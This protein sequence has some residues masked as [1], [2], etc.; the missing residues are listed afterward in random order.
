M[1]PG[2][3]TS[4]GSGDCDGSTDTTVVG[5]VCAVMDG[6]GLSNLSSVSVTYPDGQLPGESVRVSAQYEYN[7]ITPVNALINFFSAGSVGD[8]ITVSSTTDMRLE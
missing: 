7:Y 4:G 5:K 3:F 2:T 8:T 1:A 6:L